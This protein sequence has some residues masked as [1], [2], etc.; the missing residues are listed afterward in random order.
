MGE[1]E[2]LEPTIAEPTLGLLLVVV[3]EAELFCWLSKKADVDWDWG[4][5]AL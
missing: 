3:A 4:K 1:L 5:A 2:M